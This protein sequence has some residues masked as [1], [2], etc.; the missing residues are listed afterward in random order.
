MTTRTYASPEA[1]KQALERRL[2]TI[3]G[4]GA[5]FARRRQLLVFDRFLARIVAV[6]GDT[7]VLKGGLVLEYRLER[8]RTTK[9]IDLSM[10]GSP[11]DVLTRLQDAARTNLN[12]FM[13]FEVGPDTDHP[14]I[15]NEAMRY[16]GMR[17]RAECRLAGKIYGQ[18]FGVDVAFGEPILGPPEVVVAEDLLGF[19]GIAPPTLRIY[20][21]ETHVAEKLHAYTMP[22]PRPNSRVRDLPDIALLENRWSDPGEASAPS[23]RPNLRVP[24][25]SPTPGSA[26]R[27]THGL[28]SP[29][30]CDGSGGPARVGLP[31]RGRNRR[32]KVSRS[33]ARGR[34]RSHL[35]PRRLVVALSVMAS[36][37]G[38]TD[39]RTGDSS[40]RLT[41]A[42]TS[43]MNESPNPA[44]MPS[45]QCLPVR[46]AG[47]DRG[48]G[49]EVDPARS[50]GGLRCPERARRPARGGQRG[51][52]RASRRGAPSPESRAARLRRRWR[53]AG[54]RTSAHTQRLLLR[55]LGGSS[56]HRPSN[57]AWRRQARRRRLGRL[58]A[59]SAG[60][61]RVGCLAPPAPSGAGCG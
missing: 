38:R 30:R 61:R 54:E 47:R 39:A 41:I 57:C 18:P 17:F 13:T 49:S 9:D 44:G 31:R 34:T 28:G 14:V 33:R 7:A 23:P 46:S 48:P 2:R 10:M 55:R 50:R 26:A 42:S 4:G 27:S 56:R 8:A 24:R 11:E 32:E 43:S 52:K 51:G 45:K 22:R 3:A 16:D 59:R 5:D 40:I 21:L 58:H 20:P 60:R 29:L 15:Q 12:D 35:E 36:T 19:A 53:R 6:L 37:K 1:F 25:N